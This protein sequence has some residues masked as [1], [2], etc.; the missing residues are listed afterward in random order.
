MTGTVHCALLPETE[1]PICP[2]GWFDSM[3]LTRRE[4]ILPTR[5]PRLA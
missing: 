1:T 4:V 3:R 5:V 2:F